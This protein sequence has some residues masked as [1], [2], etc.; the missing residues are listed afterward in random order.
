[1]TN[2][3]NKSTIT[4]PDDMSF[5]SVQVIAWSCALAT[6]AVVIVVGNLL[7]IVLFAFNKNLRSKK[8]LYL[9]LNMAFADLF[10]GGV[11]LPMYVHFLARLPLHGQVKLDEKTP[12]IFR[13]IFFVFAQA[14]FITAALISAERFYAIYWPLKHR[15]TLST[16]AN[17]FVILTVW[18]S[19]ILGSLS[20]VFLLQF[21]SLGALNSLR[22]FIFVFA[23]L[24]ISGLNLVFGERF[25]KNLFLITKTE[26][27][28][29]DA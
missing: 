21:L 22:C 13:S 11:C 4:H 26:S 1:M 25:S 2:Q 3:T 10:F 14:S 20:I 27:C 8:S 18:T 17:R 29:D 7:T 19:S 23:I 6:E 16:R 5:T 12:T 15:Q 9:V 28:K 24:I